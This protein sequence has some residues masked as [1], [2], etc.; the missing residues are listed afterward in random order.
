ME[1][2]T[3][4]TLSAA[5][6]ALR[7]GELVVDRVFDQVFPPKIRRL[8]P[9]HW[10]P[11]EVAVRVASLLAVKPEARILD[12]GS[13]AGKFCLVAAA[14]KP[15]A[16]LRGIERRAHLVEIAEASALEL[17]VAVEFSCGT[18][19]EVDPSTVDGV[20]LFNPFAEN[21]SPR[22]DHIDDTIELGEERFWHD[23]LAVEDFLRRARVGT[24]VVTY[25]GWGGAI[26]TG[27]D[28]VLRESCAGT[29]ELWEKG[30][31]S[32]GDEAEGCP[33][34]RRFRPRARPH[35]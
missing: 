31:R 12:V 23:T 27:Y 30:Q 11:V 4:E 16:R 18:I 13:G 17:G 21:L 15:A 6:R 28:L 8:S 25:C 2:P 29:L 24:R 35:R 5:R 33:S 20:Y 26:P 10:T 19:A 9:V 1:I 3:Q 7:R 14:C 32:A 34:E 22:E